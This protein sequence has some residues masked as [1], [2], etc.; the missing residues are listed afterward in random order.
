MKR[1]LIFFSF[2]L[3]FFAEVSAKIDTI[4]TQEKGLVKMIIQQTLDAEPQV[5]KEQ[6]F[7]N[8]TGFQYSTEEV[9]KLLSGG[10][11]TKNDKSTLTSL[12]PPKLSQSWQEISLVN[13]VTVSKPETTPGELSLPFLFLGMLVPFVCIFSVSFNTPKENKK[14]PILSYFFL[15]FAA[16][17]GAGI[18]VVTGAIITNDNIAITLATIIA[19]ALAI[20]F[21]DVGVVIAAACCGIIITASFFSA[22]NKT[23][24]M[25]YVLFIIASCI[26]SHMISRLWL[27]RKERKEPTQATV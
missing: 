6:S 22:A 3:L 20:T 15:V 18:S 27:K 24:S 11:V 9:V 16:G 2:F 12:F 21:S 8:T 23:I 13:G 1:S 19:G 5:L 7:Q 17:L 14:K 26:V 4:Y 10:V 25:Q